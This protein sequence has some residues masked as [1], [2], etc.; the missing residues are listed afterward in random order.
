[1]RIS[2]CRNFIACLLAHFEMPSTV[3]FLAA[4]VRFSRKSLQVSTSVTV[5]KIGDAGDTFMVR[6]WAD[7]ADAGRVIA[8]RTG[9][10]LMGLHENRLGLHQQSRHEIYTAPR[11]GR[12]LIRA[13]GGDG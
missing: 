11:T 7:A 8:E 5:E 2:A 1:M 12:S 4:P 13:P 3:S 10:D 6:T 9:L